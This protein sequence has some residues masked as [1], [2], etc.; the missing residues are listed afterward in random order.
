M[1]D[2][3]EDSTATEPPPIPVRH[4][5]GEREAE[6]VPLVR[7]AVIVPGEAAEQ[8]FGIA[9]DDRPM[10]GHA[11]LRPFAMTRTP[12]QH[13]PAVRIL[14]DAGVRLEHAQ[15]PTTTLAVWALNPRSSARNR[16]CSSMKWNGL[17]K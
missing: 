8:S 17:V 5:T 9:A 2:G 6:L 16:S 3:D 15:S 14:D 7:G 12:E 13:G 11:D 1:P 10:V 4:V